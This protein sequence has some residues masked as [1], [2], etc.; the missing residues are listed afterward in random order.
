[1]KFA[2]II[3]DSTT[4]H[5]TEADSSGKAIENVI[6]ECRKHNIDVIKA[7]AYHLV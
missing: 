7:V 3:N 1:M 2:V 4:G 5:L 6:Q